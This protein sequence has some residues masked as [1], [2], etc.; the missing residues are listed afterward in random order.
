M[1]LFI[2]DNSM[3][4]SIQLSIMHLKV[5]F[6]QNLYT[7]DPFLKKFKVTNG[8]PKVAESKWKLYQPPPRTKLELQLN[9]RDDPK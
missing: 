7:C 6:T 8:R 4:L 2:K 5:Q 9:F 1:V 3:T